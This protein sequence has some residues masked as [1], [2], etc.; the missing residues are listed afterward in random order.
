MMIKPSRCGSA[1]GCSKVARAD[2]L[3]AAMVGAYAYGSVAV[4]EEFVAGTEVTVA[5]VDRGNGSIALPAVEI[6][7]E[8][9]VY[10]YAARYTA[11][12]TR[13]LCPAEVESDVA[14][15]CA[16]VALRVHGALGLRDLS[17]TDLIITPD[18][19]PVFLEVNVAPGMTETSAVPLAIE[20]AGW[21]LGK[22][23]ADLIRAAAARG[24]R[25]RAISLAAP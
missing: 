7:P 1:L 17:R 15:A 11:G 8:S 2:E 16:D 9:G 4:I 19:E 25:T 10:D 23:C 14:D 22:M 3:P 24:G 5:I 13:F 6:R 20:T 21:S 18:G 12:A